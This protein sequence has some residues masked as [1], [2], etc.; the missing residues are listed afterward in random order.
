MPPKGIRSIGRQ[1]APVERICSASDPQGLSIV[2]RIIQDCQFYIGSI[3]PEV[4]P[5]IYSSCPANYDVW[6]QYLGH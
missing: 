5:T 3:L 4:T 6:V 1:Q 2:H